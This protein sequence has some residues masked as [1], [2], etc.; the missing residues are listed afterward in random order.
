MTEDPTDDTRLRRSPDHKGFPEHARA[1][2]HH[3][4]LTAYEILCV[5]VRPNARNPQRMSLER[6][7]HAQAGRWSGFATALEEI[8][9]GRKSSHWIWYVFPQIVGLGRS[10]TAREYALDGLAEAEAYLRDPVLRGRY[11]EISQ[12]AEEQLARGVLLERLMGGA[13]DAL[14]MASSL[15]LF[16]AAARELAIAES[17]PVFPQ[18]AQLTDAMLARTTMQGYPACKFTLAQIN[19]KE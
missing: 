16:R 4:S 14:K 1:H 3:R 15:T 6:F 19:A 8:R 11:L 5:L 17:E 18:L 12:A 9:A 10:G 2:Q 7:H 13:T